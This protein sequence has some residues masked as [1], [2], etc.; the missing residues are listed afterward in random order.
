[1][2]HN[3]ESQVETGIYN[4]GISSVLAMRLRQ[5][6][7]ALTYIFIFSL[8]WRSLILIGPISIS[9]IVGM[10]LAIA[11]IIYRLREPFL[12]FSPSFHVPLVAFTGVVIAS[13]YWS[14]NPKRTFSYAIPFLSIFVLSIIIYDVYDSKVQVQY[15][16]T[17][18]VA[19]VGV[20]ITILVFNF[21][22][23]RT[24]IAGR[25]SIGSISGN[26]LAGLIVI[27]VLSCIF[28]IQTSRIFS[29]EW[30]EKGTNGLL[31]FVGAMAVSL[32]GSRAG[33]V[34]LTIVIAYFFV[35]EKRNLNRSRYTIV[36]AVAV[37]SM[38]FLSI[39]LFASQQT[40]ERFAS[41]I[42]DGINDNLKYR[43]VIW[44]TGFAEF[45]NNPLIGNGWGTFGP[46]TEA[47]LS[48]TYPGDFIPQ[49]AHNAFV[50]IASELGIAGLL[51]FALLLLGCGEIL[52]GFSVHEGFF[53][54]AILLVLLFLLSVDIWV[55]M[56][57]PY[58][59]MALLH[60]YKN[61]TEI[62]CP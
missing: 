24:W 28:L 61:S 40:A 46:V 42:T 52:R 7:I 41:I 2:E 36:F 11:F 23:Q 62:S 14:V 58:L 26:V 18:F 9:E 1:M 4:C 10:G 20:S 30:I 19:G 16:I 56:T 15:A 35:C 44:K 3:G 34:T 49:R 45:Q 32:T 55:T 50:T 27:G 29:N 8:P 5:I 12:S 60:T 54:L 6:V 22:T 59:F 33:F 37:F 43:I 51:P 21:L 13:T 39:T 48:Q 53:W 17:S 57:T 38:I 25:Y 47:T 31:I